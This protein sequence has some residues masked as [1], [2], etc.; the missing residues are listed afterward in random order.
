MQERQGN[1]LSSLGFSFNSVI[2]EGE[3][4]Y[5]GATKGS[6]SVP[7]Q[8]PETGFPLGR[9]LMCT[10]VC[11]GISRQEGSGAVTQALG[12]GGRAVG[13]RGYLGMLG[14]SEDK[15]GLLDWLES[16]SKSAAS[17]SKSPLPS[18]VSSKSSFSSWMNN[19]PTL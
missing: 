19:N 8:A 16:A 1:V 3:N 14:A 17:P 18:P 9:G 15:F 2:T 5:W 11:S 10:V 4:R 7:P 12:D 13:T 6:A